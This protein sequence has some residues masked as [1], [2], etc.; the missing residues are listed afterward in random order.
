MVFLPFLVTTL[1]IGPRH[2]SRAAA[3]LQSSSQGASSTADA[4]PGA[5]VSA[6]S[7]SSHAVAAV[8]NG[9]RGKA[10]ATPVNNFRPGAACDATA[11]SKYAVR[12]VS[13]NSTPENPRP[14][15][16]GPDPRSCPT[17]AESSPRPRCTVEQHVGINPRTVSFDGKTAQAR[18]GRVACLRL[19]KRKL[20]C[21]LVAELLGQRPLAH[22]HRPPEPAPEQRGDGRC[23]E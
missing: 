11:A 12:P 16:A 19:K 5:A 18:P 4:A 1:R 9:L 2:C 23:H 22:Q 21:V 3:R 20:P 14:A 6:A 10:T 7:C 17:A 13:V 15:H 8:T